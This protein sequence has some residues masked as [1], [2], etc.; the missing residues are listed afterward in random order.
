MPSDFLLLTAEPH[1]ITITQARK[2]AQRLLTTKYIQ[3]KNIRLS[4]KEVASIAAVVHTSEQ[5]KIYDGVNFSRMQIPTIL[6]QYAEGSR[7]EFETLG[8]YLSNYVHSNGIITLDNITNEDA[9]GLELARLFRTLFPDGRLISLYDDYNGKP[10]LQDDNDAYVPFDALMTRNFRIS[11]RDLFRSQGVILP[12]HKT[13]EDFLLLSEAAS[14][15]AADELVHNLEMRG[16]IR[17]MEQAIIFFNND[18][19]NPLHRY[20]YLR[21]RQGRWLCEALDAATFL[22]EHNLQVVH[23]VALPDYMRPQQDKVWEILRVLG[24]QPARYHNIFF[25]PRGDPKAVADCVLKAFMTAPNTR[26]I[27]QL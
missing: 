19:E 10:A 15:S 17:R 24:L 7:I 4:K 25:N 27:Y 3:G 8:P 5:A 21:T 22:A 18:A 11:L 23:I 14:I 1:H 9:I 13:T 2:L 12:A 6:S 26:Y 16:Y 20:F